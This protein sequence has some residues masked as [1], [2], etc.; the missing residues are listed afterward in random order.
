MVL[1]LESKH[2]KWLKNS[3]GSLYVNVLF[4][5]RLFPHF[6]WFWGGKG[7]NCMDFSSLSCFMLW[8]WPWWGSYP[9]DQLT[10]GWASQLSTCYCAVPENWSQGLACPCTH[11]YL[12]GGGNVNTEKHRILHDKWRCHNPQQWLSPGGHFCPLVDT[13]FAVMTGGGGSYWHLVDKS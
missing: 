9:D 8:I 12:N 7:C 6:F 4:L 10:G 3:E 5:L 1:C 2:Q 11:T 13:V